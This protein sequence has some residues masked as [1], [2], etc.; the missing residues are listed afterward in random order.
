MQ[1][2]I[3]ELFVNSFLGNFIVVKK[4]DVFLAVPR[5]RPFTEDDQKVVLVDVLLFNNFCPGFQF[6]FLYK[7]IR[8]ACRHK[9]VV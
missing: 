2:N 9:Q 6:P 8:L 1:L 3:D 5:N 4:A 7:G